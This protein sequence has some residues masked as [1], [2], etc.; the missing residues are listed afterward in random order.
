MNRRQ[1]LA[2]SGAGF[3]AACG[4]GSRAGSGRFTVWGGEGLRD[5]SF[6][7]P[8]AIGVH[9]GEVYVIDTTGRVQ[10]FSTTGE[11]L[12]LW[13]TPDA[14]NGTPTAIAFDADGNLLVPDTHY[15]QILEY[16]PS[17]ELTTKWGSY[18]NGTDQFIYPTG[19]EQSPGGH[20]FVSE[21]GEGAERV[22]VFDSECRFVRQWGK[23]GDQPGEFNRAMAL[24]L[25]D[26]TVFVADT[27][28]HRVQ[29]FDHEGKTKGVIGSG[30]TEPGQ[31]KYP[32]DIALGPDGL[33]YV[34]EYGTH[35][36]SRFSADGAFQGAW[37][38]PG[39]DPGEFNAPRGVA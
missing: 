13:S 26:D 14:E 30:G 25:S 1:F 35:R 19:I 32:H 10:V 17:G 8:R 38:S 20:Y 36:I 18:G 37:G 33:V 2:L 11:F 29:C 27:A 12:R 28:N 22:H 24:A 34:A 23:H 21:Y 5:G 15:S 6:L 9:G 16:T 39:R 4:Q 7:R 31:L 3:L